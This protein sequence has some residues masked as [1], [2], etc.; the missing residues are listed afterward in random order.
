[1]YSGYLALAGN[2]IVN[3]ARASAYATSLGIT[4]L[5]CQPC[6]T[7]RR[8]VW[9]DPYS[10]PEAD[11]A[12][13]FDPAEP[14][15]R[16]FAGFVGLDVTGLS[17]SSATR[18]LTPL[19]DNG[20]IL[21]PV[22]RSHREIQ[23][24]VLAMAKT[25]CALTYGI[26]WLSSALRGRVC[27]TGC[28]GDT[29]CFFTCCPECPPWDSIA[30]PTD[31]C[32]DLSTQS[33]R[34]LHNVGLL[35]AEQP[36]QVRRISGGWIGQITYTLAAGDPFIYREPILMALGPRPDQI[37]PNY[38]DPGVPATCSEAT[39]CLRDPSCPAPPAPVLPPPPIDACFP[40]GPFT[41]ARVVFSLPDG[42]APIWP[43]KVPLVFIKAGATKMERL[44]IRWYGNA[45]EAD[46]ATGLDPCAACAEVSIPFIPAGATLTIDGR[47]E[48]AF[49]DCPGGP[50]LTTAEPVLYGRGGTPFVW[51][52]FSCGTGMCMEIIAKANTVAA[53]AQIEIYY[54]VREDAA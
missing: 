25:E 9:D 20:A 1:M 23:V 44:T 5:G 35:S 38:T 24:D 42:R 18:A 15:S 27:D 53:D 12:P 45:R 22:R 11:D 14:S 31:P 48:T 2:E 33:Y 41:A 47:T 43:E 32:I 16:E 30:D 8:A 4:T 50:G 7:L 6:S 54:V 46:C 51:P 10:T 29:L 21:G 19:A 37:M 3:N 28:G 13:W 49:V 40:T 26:S 39:D 52:V 34:Y 36:T 17:R